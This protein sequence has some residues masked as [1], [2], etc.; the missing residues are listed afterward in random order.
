MKQIK[1][2]Y[3][4]HKCCYNSILINITYC[5][6]LI[7]FCIPIS[8]SGDDSVM[9]TI[10]SGG[11]GD[12]NS[13]I[14]FSNIYY[15]KIIWYLNRLCSS[16]NW[17]Y[18]IQYI[19]M[20]ISFSLI[21]YFIIKKIDGKKKYVVCILFLMCFGYDVYI[22]QQFTKTAALISAAGCMTILEELEKREWKFIIIGSI[23][24]I[25]GSMIRFHSFLATLGM[26]SI[27]IVYKIYKLYEN[28]NF[29]FI[30]KGFA[31]GIVILGVTFGLRYLDKVEYNTDGWR[32][33]RE[34]NSARSSVRDYPIAN[35][36]NA[37][38]EYKKIGVESADYYNL[39]QWNIGDP[40]YYT[41]EKLIKISNVKA[42]KL[43][44]SDNNENQVLSS[45]KFYIKY[46]LS[47]SWIYFYLACSFMFIYYYG[48]KK[49]NILKIIIPLLPLVFLSIYLFL[50]GRYGMQRLELIL[51]ISSSLELIMFFFNDK[52]ERTKKNIYLILIFLV[53]VPI[54]GERYFANYSIKNSYKESIN[55]KKNLYNILNDRPQNTYFMDASTGYMG[56]SFFIFEPYPIGYASNVLGLGGWYTN[57]PV[58]N[59]ALNNRN[60]SNPF[61]DGINNENIF[62]I[63][64]SDFETQLEYIQEHYDE[65]AKKELVETIGPYNIYAI[66]S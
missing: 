60:I 64:K 36:E 1:A 65:K 39:L 3:S 44:E 17:Y 59:D 61:R 18:I 66:R 14:V 23:L 37:S 62:Y 19:L 58:L 43:S 25:F 52:E 9:M 16:I 45:I 48:M 20:F 51:W 30:K 42:N 32:E 41:T 47:Q 8:D 46:Y 53:T 12:N 29:E 31:I 35:Y 11:L 24:L 28:K 4:K 21:I 50:K 15:A 56:E 6:V 26:F 33:Y 57:S 38:E 40:E 49:N 54:F 22:A 5:L 27:F 34:F 55:I 13:H 7:G 63:T 10:L 2:I